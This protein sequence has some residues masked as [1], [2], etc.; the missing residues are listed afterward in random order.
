ML[1]FSLLVSKTHRSSSREA[2]LCYVMVG[3]VLGARHLRQDR[4]QEKNSDRIGEMSFVPFSL[5]HGVGKLGAKILI[6]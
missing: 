2:Q 3:W 4:T 5:V 1:F 6:E